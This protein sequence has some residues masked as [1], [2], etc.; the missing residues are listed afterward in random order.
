M[1]PTQRGGEPTTS[2]VVGL[3]RINR[4]RVLRRLVFDPD[5]NSRPALVAATGLS[6]SKITQVVRQLI[7]QGLVQEHGTVPSN[8]GRPIVELSPRPAGAHVIG[9]EVSEHD[10]TVELFDLSLQ[11]VAHQDRQLGGSVADPHHVTRALCESVA[12]VLADLDEARRDTVIG[13]GLALPGLVEPDADGGPMLH[14]DQL[15][16]EPIRLSSL[17]SADLPVYADNGA[18]ALAAAETDVGGARNTQEAAVVLIGHGVGAA[19]VSH[20]RLLRGRSNSAGEWGHTKVMLGGPECSCGARG[21]LE[22]LIGGGALARQWGGLA[23]DRDASERDVIADLLAAD[24]AGDPG[25]RDIVDDAIA[26]LGVGLANLVNLHNPER[27]VIGGW[28]GAALLAARRSDL[29]AATK[30]NSLA[31]PYQGVS[32][33]PAQLGMDAVPLGAALLPLSH[34]INDTLTT[35]S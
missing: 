19:L 21:C 27:I 12:S 32:L 3:R 17:F 34:F 2:T 13:I 4:T 35:R 10:V 6:A 24:R 8:G 16:W 11:R 15:G 26:A 18:R 9:A 30:A 20:G 22:A 1:K 25:A 7:D 23:D 31:R 29:E 5:A 14:A 33:Q 28:A